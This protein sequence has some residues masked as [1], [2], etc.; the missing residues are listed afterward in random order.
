M[1]IAVVIIEMVSM[2]IVRLELWDK[3]YGTT[4]N[5]NYGPI[6]DTSWHGCV[7]SRRRRVGGMSSM[8]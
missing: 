1:I 8:W 2:P 3:G 4:E 7:S 5:K 6:V